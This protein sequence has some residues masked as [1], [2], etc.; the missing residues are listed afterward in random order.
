MLSWS[1]MGFEEGEDQVDEEGVIEEERRVVSDDIAL[2]LASPCAPPRGDR[3]SG[4]FSS[5]W[6]MSEVG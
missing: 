5:L 4:S 6:A 1:C 3:F 2:G